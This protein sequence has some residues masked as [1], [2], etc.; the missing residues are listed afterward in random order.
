[1]NLKP[2]GDK[3][4]IERVEQEQRTQSGI[5]L[6]ETAKEKPQEGKVLAVGPG[7][8]LESG[9]HQPMQVSEGDRVLFARYAGTE[10]KLGDRDVLIL[11]ENDVLAIIE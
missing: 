2:L 4:V 7:K 10:F 9:E 8:R 5:V 6:P 11:A 1:M 3:L